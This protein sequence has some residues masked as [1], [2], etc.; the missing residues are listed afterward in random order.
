MSRLDFM[1]KRLTAQRMLLGEAAR[2]IAHKQGCVFELG[3]GSGRTFDHLRELLPD[4]E[5]FA[6]DRSIAA[7]PKC[8]PDGDHMILGEI[9][10]TLEFCAPRIPGKPALI[11]VDLGSGDPTQDM[12]T[13]AWLSP[14]IKEWAAPGTIIL[15][16][17]PLDL[18]FEELPRPAGCPESGHRLL[19]AA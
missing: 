19:R 7:H 12:I 11:H 2:L 1:I 17:R 15:A 4:R 8:I 13:R 10:E 16:D 6:F 9:R 5:I 14:R 18:P 3:L